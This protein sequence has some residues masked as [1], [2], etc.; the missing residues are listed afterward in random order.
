MKRA[1]RLGDYKTLNIYVLDDLLHEP[2][3]PGE[4]NRPLGMCTFPHV[5]APNSPAIVMQ[6]GCI[7]RAD[8]IP[9]MKLENPVT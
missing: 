1:Y 8:T 3:I 5:D 4:D 6:D 2:Y 9:D 7:I